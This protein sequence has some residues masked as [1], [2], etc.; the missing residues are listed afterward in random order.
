[1]TQ[2]QLQ[3]LQCLAIPL[4]PQTTPCPQTADVR[5]GGSD[6][7][8]GWGSESTSQKAVQTEPLEILAL[9]SSSWFA[10]KGCISVPGI[11]DCVREAPLRPRVRG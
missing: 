7:W 11:G 5:P 1:M 9:S 8:S 6:G 4:L 2:L 3:L 10:R